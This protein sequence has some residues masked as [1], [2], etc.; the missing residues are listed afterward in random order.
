M[1]LFNRQW[2]QIALST[3]KCC[4]RV[5]GYSLVCVMIIMLRT[6]HEGSRLMS[7][8]GFGSCLETPD[9]T[10]N[11]VHGL[12]TACLN[13]NIVVTLLF[14]MLQVYFTRH[15]TS[16]GSAFYLLVQSFTTQWLKKA[17]LLFNIK[18]KYRSDFNNF[19]VYIK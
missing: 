10:L 3:A 13:K 11:R 5:L 8:S 16:L 4:F 6:D 7:N 19:F 18:K 2:A 14:S 9:F 12:I 1:K 15:F 17:L